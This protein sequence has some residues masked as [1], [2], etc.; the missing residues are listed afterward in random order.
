LLA[1]MPSIFSGAE[2]PVSF[3]RPGFRALANPSPR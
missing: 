2:L 1:R 3:G